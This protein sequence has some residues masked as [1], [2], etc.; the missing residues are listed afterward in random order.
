M[1]HYFSL[2]ILF[3]YRYHC[4][5]LVS[6]CVEVSWLINIGYWRPHTV[7]DSKEFS[8]SIPYHNVF[9]NN[10]EVENYYHFHMFHLV[11]N[12]VN[13]LH[14]RSNAV[15]DFKIICFPSSPKIWFYIHVQL[16]YH[17]HLVFILSE[18]LAIFTIISGNQDVPYQIFQ[19]FFDNKFKILAF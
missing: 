12:K 16:K 11:K 2:H 8:L 6:I 13:I 19:D 15:F 4:G 9:S 14:A 10:I 17:V 5:C 18:V 3:V 7:S 1:S